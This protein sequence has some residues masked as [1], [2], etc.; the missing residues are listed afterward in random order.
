MVGGVDLY[1]AVADDR[2]RYIRYCAIEY[3][4]TAN[5]AANAILGLIHSKFGTPQ[6][7][8][9]RSMLINILTDVP[10]NLQAGEQTATTNADY[11]VPSIYIAGI[12]ILVPPLFQIRTF[13]SG[14]AKAQISMIVH[15]TT[16]LAWLSVVI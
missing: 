9:D 14:F 16:N 4:K 1:P 13:Q 12:G 8:W 7:I 5:P 11:F 3:S 2:W 10:N 6:P 15:E